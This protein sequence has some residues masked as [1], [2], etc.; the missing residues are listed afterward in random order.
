M[1]RSRLNVWLCR[2]LAGAALL[3]AG[4]AA[5]PPADSPPA[6]SPSRPKTTVTTPQQQQDPQQAPPIAAKPIRIAGDSCEIRMHDLC[7]PLLLYYQLFSEFPE[8]L[9]DLRLLPGF[10]Q[11]AEFSC[12]TSGRPYVYKPK[13]MFNPD[14][15]GGV[16]LYDSV[17]SHAG[18]R[19]AIQVAISEKTGRPTALVVPMTEDVFKNLRAAP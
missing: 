13:G 12:P 17:P 7:G 3:L 10:D 15:T 14:G 4:C 18:L 2:H 1:H 16:I 19:W 8:S 5:A 9:A 11:I 6:P